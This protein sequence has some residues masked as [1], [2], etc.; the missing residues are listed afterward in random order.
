MAKQQFTPSNS[1][2]IERPTCA[3]CGSP[4]WLARITPSDKPGYDMR[5]F[6][7]PVCEISETAAVKI[8]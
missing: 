3:K 1:P 6:D 5:T 7:C 8:T 4:M 2:R